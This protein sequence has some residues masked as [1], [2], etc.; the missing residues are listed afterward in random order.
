LK[1]RKVLTFNNSAA[2]TGVPLGKV[3]ALVVPFIVSVTGRVSVAS[4][5]ITLETTTVK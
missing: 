3:N 4:A 5:G 2:V 1:T